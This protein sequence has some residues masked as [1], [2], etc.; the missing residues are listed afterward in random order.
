MAAEARD[1]A[2]DLARQLRVFSRRAVESLRQIFR[3]DGERARAAVRH[4]EVDQHAPVLGAH[5][6]LERAR[7]RGVRLHHPA[8]GARVHLAQCLGR[9][10]RVHVP[11]LRAELAGEN[12]GVFRCKAGLDERGGAGVGAVRVAVFVHL[13]RADGVAL[14]PDITH[15]LEVAHDARR[16]RRLPAQSLGHPFGCTRVFA[17]RLVEPAC[18]VVALGKRRV[19]RDLIQALGVRGAVQRVQ[20]LRRTA[21]LALRLEEVLRLCD[22]LRRRIRQRIGEDAAEPLPEIPRVERRVRER[23][24]PRLDPPQDGS[25]PRIGRRPCRELRL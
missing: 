20:F 7:E 9:G 6:A 1:N 18:G 24:R 19:L 17:V 13:A 8:R 14:R 4:R 12:R 5:L 16:V 2:F 3:L 22:L 15:G 25:H 23:C 11:A 10:G 21:R